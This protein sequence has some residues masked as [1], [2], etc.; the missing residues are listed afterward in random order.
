LIVSTSPQNNI[1]LCQHG[2]DC[3]ADSGATVSAA[4]GV[5]QQ[6]YFDTEADNK[7]A[8]SFSSEVFC[9]S[10]LQYALRCQWMHY[11]IVD[12]SAAADNYEYDYYECGHMH[13]YGFLD[14]EPENALNDHGGGAFAVLLMHE[15]HTP[16]LDN[17]YPRH[18]FHCAGGSWEPE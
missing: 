12:D 11:G 16:T 3:T 10:V 18:G 6:H 8:E 9:H 13:E 4:D 15:V 17:A 5:P 2:T 1:V 7:A 14:Y